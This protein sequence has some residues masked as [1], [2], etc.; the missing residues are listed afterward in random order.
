MAWADVVI[1]HGGHGTVMK[2]LVAGKPILFLPHGR[3]QDDNAVRVTHR[4]AGLSLSATS[5][6]ADMGAALRRL[7]DEPGFAAN[8]RRLGD[9]VAH[10]ARHSSIVSVLERLAAMPRVVAGLRVA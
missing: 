8:A 4:G 5:S 9:Q 7:L 3:D 10:D 6:V 1:T 2:A